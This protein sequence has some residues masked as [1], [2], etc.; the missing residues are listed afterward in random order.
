MTKRIVSI[1]LILVTTLSFTGCKKENNVKETGRYVEEALSLPDGVTENRVVSVTKSPKQELVIFAN[2]YG[3]YTQY[4]FHENAWVSEP[5]KWLSKNNISSFKHIF[6]GED[7]NRY[8]L[9]IGLDFKVILLKS[10]DGIENEVI[11]TPF[12]KS[13]PVFCEVLRNGDI[14]ITF[15]DEPNLYIVSSEDG[16]VL[17][18]LD[19]AYGFKA[20]GDLLLASDVTNKKVLIY[21]S[22]EN[23]SVTEKDNIH[24][25]DY[26]QKIFAGENEGDIYLADKKGIHLLEA[27]GTMWQTIVDGDTSY[28]SIP[29]YALQYIFAVD[30]VF[31]ATFINKDDWSYITKQY[32]F[33]PTAKAFTDET[34]TIFSLKDNDMIR[35]AVIQ[36]QVLHPDVKIL[37]RVAM[38]NDEG[39][40]VNDYIRSFNTELLAGKGADIIV[41]DGMPIEDYVEKGALKD[42]TAVIE[43]LIASDML[44][45]NI[46]EPIK[47]DGHYYNIP[48]LFS[49]PIVYGEAELLELATLEGLNK[50]Y[51]DNNRPLCLTSSLTTLANYYV[52][53]NLNTFIDQGNKFDSEKYKEILTNIGSIE[54]QSPSVGNYEELFWKRHLSEV[55]AS[56]F[57]VDDFQMN[58]DD[59]LVAVAEVL[60][61]C[62]FQ[63]LFALSDTIESKYSTINNQ[64]VPYGMIGINSSTSQG[65]LAEEFINY[66]LSETV[67]SAIPDGL[68]VRKD[69]LKNLLYQAVYNQSNMHRAFDSCSCP[70]TRFEL[71]F[72]DDE[73]ASVVFEMLMSL[74]TPIHCDSILINL[75]S[76]ELEA[77]F[78]GDKTSYE[79][80]ESVKKKVETY[81]AE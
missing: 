41:L 72:L 42:I 35:S 8:A 61:Y 24:N 60:A 29:S 10:Q 18:E 38:E 71:A 51:N 16:D 34:L 54:E 12:T 1:I 57:I 65:D 36:F 37:Y 81:L 78:A 4:T 56:K 45:Q 30:Q 11:K 80:A 79:T 53:T 31:Y 47:K 67:Q 55:K 33:D 50:Y 75:L 76:S 5:A 6:Y 43:P 25:L 40:P 2:E 77:Y 32:R 74:D 26:N 14:A 64:F 17:H 48:T 73:K 66:M 63:A 44:M 28:F 3:Q 23:Y 22:T 39:L 68:P 27:G 69:M 7:G 46:V 49:V 62:D 9:G 13:S 59:N 20:D 70:G 15:S 52:L 21:D 19:Y 58:T